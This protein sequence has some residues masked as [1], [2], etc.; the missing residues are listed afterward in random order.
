MNLSDLY[1]RSPVVVQN[2]M[3]TGYGLRERARRYHG[4]FRHLVDELNVRQWADPDELRADQLA[5][6]RRQLTWCAAEVPHYRDQFRELG[7]DPRDLADVAGLEALPVLDKEVVRTDPERFVADRD[8]GHLIAQ[9]TGG[10]TGTPLR[11]WATLD[12]VRANY[13]T[14]E[15]RSRRWAGTRFGDRTA[16]LHGQP[17]VPAADQDGPFWRRN[18]AFNQ[19]YLSVYHLNDRTLPAYI[20]ALAAFDPR[21][22]VGY[23]SAVHRLATHLLETGDVGRVS[24]STVMVSSETL[25]AAARHDIETAFGCRVFNG[26]SLGELVAYVSECPHGSLHVSTEYGVLELVETEVG[27]E[28]VATGLINRGMPLVRYRT[29][30]LAVASDRPCSC[31][32]GLPVLSELQ[33]RADDVVRTPEGSVVGPAPMSLAFQRVQRLRRA[34]VLQDAPEAITVLLEPAPGFDADDQAFLDQE[35]RK[36]LGSTLAITYERV[37]ALPRTSG[38]KERLIVSSIGRDRPTA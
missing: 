30:D 27:S 14:Y 24:P 1:G 37:E 6:L 12:A 26:Y 29:S 2:A 36:R 18:L 13:A 34:Q 23:M 8:R 20:D 15:A 10:T 19:L 4:S 3:A 16:S 21:V 22:V 17:I 5:R 11:Y 9:T 38:G 31:G 25:T 35:L 32:R 28:I 7:F 33:G